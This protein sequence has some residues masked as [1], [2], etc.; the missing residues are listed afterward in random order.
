MARRRVVALAL[1]LSPLAAPG[2]VKGGVAGL[3]RD[4]R[5]AATTAR[6]A[7]QA[8]GTVHVLACATE[9]R[10]E[11]AIL[12]RSAA[13]N[14]LRFH[15]V[16]LGKPWR[17]F[18]TKFLSYAE[19][20][21]ELRPR[22]SSEDRVM[23]LDA[24]DTV[25]LGTSDELMAKLATLPEGSVLCGAER[26]CGPNHFLVAQVEALYPE[27][28]TPWRYPNSGGIIG[29]P[30]VMAELLHA[31]IHDTEDGQTLP[32]EENDQVRLHDL[33]IARARNG[34]R[35]PLVL[36]TDC[37]VFQCMYE[38]QPQWDVV[39]DESET[40]ARPRLVNKLTKERPVVAHGNGHTG[41]WFL[42]A[43]Y[44]EMQLLQYLGLSMGELQHLRHE[45]PVPPGTQVTE[46]IKA[47]YCPWW[48]MPGMHKGATD[49]FA[50]FRQIRD[51]LCR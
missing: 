31:L 29:P 10:Q 5:R 46:E 43:M 35:F 20:L 41:R 8:A 36:D 40:P 25:I 18:A 2:F 33:L 7:A 21:E 51:M 26:V 15:A 17:G 50:S 47:E 13:R 6:R 34:R 27:N 19:K 48:Y 42:S 11:T 3:R 1:L 45:M 12:Q 14:G 38:E 39:L 23:L 30:Q 4:A 32:A 44:S 28:H 9:Y 37:R 22:L 24:W 16:G 49:G